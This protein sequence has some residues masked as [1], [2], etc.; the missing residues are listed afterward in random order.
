MRLKSQYIISIAIFGILLTIISASVIFTNQQVAQINNKEQMAGNIQTGASN[1]AYISNDYFLYQQSAQLSQWQNQFSSLLYD[2]SKLIPNGPEQQSQIN[3]VKTDLQNLGSVFNSSVSF[4]EGTPRNESLRVLP[5]F[6]TDWDRLA[7]Q[8][9]ALTFDASV[10]SKSFGDQANQLKQTN[11][12]LILSLIGTFGA[13]FVAVYFLVYGRTLKSIAKLQDGTKI[14][15]SGNLDYSV[16]S[17]SN[18]EVGELS[19]AFNQMTINLKSV[20]ASKTDLEEEIA[21]RKK[22]EEELVTTKDRLAEEL[23]GSLR[24]QKLGMIFVSE[25]NLQALLDEIVFA[26][27]EI[28]HADMGNMQQITKDGE[29]RIVAQSGFKQSFLDFFNCVSDDSHA[30]CAAAMASKKRVIVKDVTQSSIFL[31][32]P[33]LNV[34]LEAGVRAVVS[35]PFFTRSG[36]FLGIISTHFRSAREPDEFDLRLLDLLVRQAADLVERTQTEQKLED[37]AKNLEKLVEERT[38]QL[39]DSE[40]LAAIGAT[41]GMVGHDIRN[42]LQAITG[43]VYLLKSELSSMPDSEDK[44]SVKESLDGIEKNID[45]INKIVADLQD[46][47]RPLKPNV[48]ET[49][50]KLII[51]QLLAKNSLPENVKVSVKVETGKFVADTTYLNRILYNLVNNAV[52]AMPKG[53]QLTIHAYKDKDDINIA[54]KDT[55]VGIPNNVKNKLFTPMFTTKSKGQGFGLAVIKRMTEALDGTVTF[56]SQEGKGTTFIVHLPPKK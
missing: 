36:E 40:R 52:Q 6:Q 35:T 4:I 11:N 48:E 33:A 13:Y 2:L 29:L 23:A 43:D 38:K 3:N 44:E 27:I 50:L 53:G 10:L 25:A 19:R 12:I 14:I 47:A 54:V 5:A 18:D 41:A 30:A 46:F 39:K 37:Y 21:E 17:K 55:G 8:N 7:L 26:A 1:L 9:Q 24:L 49:D 51:D 42:P 32:T 20:T 34:L 56:E 31:N 45:Y 22:A 15:G 16:A 28:M